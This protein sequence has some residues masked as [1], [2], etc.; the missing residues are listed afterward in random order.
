MALGSA[1]VTGDEVRQQVLDVARAL[2]PA[3]L[4]VGTAG[5]VSG[6]LPDGATVCMTPSARPYDQLTVDDLVTVRLDGTEL[7]DAR[8]ARGSATTEKALHLACYRRHPEIGG[9]V[10]THAPHASMFAVARQP[11]PAAVEE[12]VV[13]IGGDIPVC[14]YHPTGTD[15]LGDEVAAR[16]ADRSAV[17]LANHGL[18]CIGRDAGDALHVTLVAERTAQIVWGAHLLG[19]LGEIPAAVDDRFAAQYRAARHRR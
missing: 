16:L 12:V 13:A 9:V 8:G 18:V 19:P 7:G 10:H 15:E 6:R 3:G 14:A 17:L 11:V 4:V 1:A 2:P 5:N